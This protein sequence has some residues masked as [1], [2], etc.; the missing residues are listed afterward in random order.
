[1]GSS[2]IPFI[3]LKF[4]KDLK[5]FFLCGLYLLIFVALKLEE[6]FSKICYLKYYVKGYL[7]GSVG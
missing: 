5:G 1:M 3:L 4:T 7:G 2:Q 6:F